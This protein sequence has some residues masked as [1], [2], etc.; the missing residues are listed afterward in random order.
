MIRFESAPLIPRQPKLGNRELDVRASLLTRPAGVLSSL[1]PM[2]P[3]CFLALAREEA[4]KKGELDRHDRLSIGC[5]VC[6]CDWRTTWGAL[7]KLCLISYKQ[8]LLRDDRS[9]RLA[10][11]TYWV[12]VLGLQAYNDHVRWNEELKS[13]IAADEAEVRNAP[14]GVAKAPRHI[15]S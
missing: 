12:T 6:E 13:A 8:S 11:V 1:D 4:Q 3:A 2:A 7:A 15:R 10:T 5:L 14:R 9:G